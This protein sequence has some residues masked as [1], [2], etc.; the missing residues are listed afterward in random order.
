MKNKILLWSVPEKPTTLP[1]IVWQNRG[2]EV[3]EMRRFRVFSDRSNARTAQIW[4]L[5]HQ[6]FHFL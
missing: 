2:F 5:E 3:P 6:D 4:C 1:T